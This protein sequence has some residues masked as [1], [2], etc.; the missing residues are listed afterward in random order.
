MNLIKAILVDDE[1]RANSVLKELLLKSQFEIEIL[2]ICQN[3]PEGVKAI[4]K[5]KPDVVF[6]DIQMPNYA[7]YEI[8]TFFEKINFEIIFI[9]AFDQYA[10]KAF[11]LCAADYLVK[12]I[13]RKRLNE[14][15]L[16]LQSRI[17]NKNRLEQYKTLLKTIQN[18]RQEKIVIPEMGNRRIINISEIIAIEADGA[19]TCIHIKS[20]PKVTTSR[21]L[22]YYENLL[23]DNS[24]FYRAHRSWLINSNYLKTF[25]RTTST[26]F[27][28][29]EV[30]AKIARKQYNE[31]IEFCEKPK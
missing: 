22:K 14:S 26:L 29:D 27:L 12:P 30:K 9:T 31:F 2:A 18:K 1:P 16:K 8:A 25:N 13:N 5:L 23:V 7:G 28:A 10:I 20:S 21:N 24:H 11:E 3:L 19:Y 4:K 15:L 6:L 17:E